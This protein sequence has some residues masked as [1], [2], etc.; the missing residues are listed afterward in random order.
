MN[1]Y[2]LTALSVL[3]L[4]ATCANAANV[5]TPY[6]GI[7]A[8]YSTLKATHIKPHYFGGGVHIGTTYNTYFGTEVFY[9]QFGQNVKKIDAGQKLKTSYRAYG[10][11]MVGYLPLIKENKFVLFSSIG[12]GEYVVRHKMTGQKHK[13]NTGYAYRF[14][15]GAM[16]GLSEHWSIRILARYAKMHHIDGLN[17]AWTYGIG[18]RYNFAREQ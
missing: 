11:D 4:Y 5:Y 16:F 18:L 8:L 12:A 3:S 13:N 10:L 6:V 14:G 15:G 2:F 9:E 1:K 17:H 7:D